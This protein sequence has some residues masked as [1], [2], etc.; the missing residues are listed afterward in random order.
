[1]LA[2]TELTVD[3]GFHVLAVM[4]EPDVML[5]GLTVQISLLALLQ[6]QLLGA[7]L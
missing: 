6:A 7:I 2:C 1:M 3:L 5:A 4:N